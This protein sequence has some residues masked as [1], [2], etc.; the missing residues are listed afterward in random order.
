MN[1][2]SNE[3]S[4]YLL[5]HVHNPVDWYPWGQEAFDRAEAEDKP[6]FLSIGYSTC[7]WCHV[8][9]H[10]S[11]E[12]EEVA[13]VLN[14]HYISIKVDREEQPDVDAVYMAACQA[15]TG[16]GGWPLT[17]IMTPHQK[18]FFVGTYFPKYPRY[19]QAGLLDILNK[20]GNLWKSNRAQLVKTGRDITSFLENSEET[21][22]K[23][24]EKELVKQAAGLFRQQFDTKWGGFGKAPKF[25]T[26]HNLLFLMEYSVLEKD[27]EAIKMALVTL[28]SMARGGIWD[29]I[30]GGFSRYSTDEKWLAPHFEKMLY[31]NALLTIAYLKA[32][33]LTKQPHYAKI[34]EDTLD[35]ILQEL[36]GP[37]GEFYC[38][39]DAD[40]DGVEGKYY[41]FTPR[42]V[43][44]VLGEQ[45]GEAFCHLYQITDEGN[46]EGKSIPNRIH[47]QEKAWDL[48][49]SRIQ[50]LYEYRL[51]RTSLHRDDKVLLSWNGWVMIALAMAARILGEKRYLE[52]ALRANAFI[53]RYMQDENRRLY[54]RWREGQAAFLG[55][56]DDYAVYGLALL[57]LYQTTYDT[58]YLKEALFR[59]EQIQELFKDQEK[60]GYF[61]TAKDAKSL[62]FRPKEAY[63]GAIPSGN[64]AA[65]MLFGALSRYTGSLELRQTSDQQLAFLAGNIQQYPPGYSFGLLSLMGTLYPSSEFV[66][67]A[68]DEKVPRELS[69]FLKE[70]Y[71]PNVSVIVKTT[72]NQQELAQLI[73]FTKEFPIPDKKATFY[74]CKDGKCMKPK[75]KL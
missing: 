34:A 64:S 33:H 32:Y 60:G 25:P 12:D 7:H 61:L 28:E 57:E 52:N 74:M 3:K 50:K 11:F 37:Q 54:H 40:S 14:E 22:S 35:Y 70:R 16:S 38:G 56:L 43:K 10:E 72:E 48:K 24:P 39:Q 2:L 27:M 30:G 73:P 42:E 59:A 58:C 44:E 49:D 15:A 65:A 55:Q 19:G 75:T 13:S 71:I 68:P 29:H 46:F 6:I 62:I 17:V 26:P 9:A 5:Q 45:D 21:E 66:C 18:P 36:T 41:V 8:M 51:R 53:E 63:D 69:A 4:P 47:N 31:D 1:H 67:V 23:V 20:L